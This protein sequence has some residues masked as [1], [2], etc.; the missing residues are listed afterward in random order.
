MMDD[1]TFIKEVCDIAFG[2]G[3]IDRGY[4]R[5][6]VL[7]KLREFSDNALIDWRAF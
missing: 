1:I 6:E 5:K 7:A 3:A 2:D 4:E